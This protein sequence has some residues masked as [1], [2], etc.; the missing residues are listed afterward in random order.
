MSKTGQQNKASLHT[1]ILTMHG[2]DFV[3]LNFTNLLESVTMI[4]CQC[5]LGLSY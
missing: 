2:S 3:D 5:W 4:T 1:P